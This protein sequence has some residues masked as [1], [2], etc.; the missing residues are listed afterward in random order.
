MPLSLAITIAASCISNGNNL[1]P[2]AL[3]FGGEE[4]RL[5]P[6]SFLFETKKSR[7]ICFSLPGFSL[8]SGLCDDAAEAAEAERCKPAVR[9]PMPAEAVDIHRMDTAEAAV[10]DTHNKPAAV[11]AAQPCRPRAQ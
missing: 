9:D 7:R 6:P 2:V 10:A 5:S 8:T 4:S 3:N 11:V 1:A